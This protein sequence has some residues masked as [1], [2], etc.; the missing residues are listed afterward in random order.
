MADFI[1]NVEELNHYFCTI[2]VIYGFPY[3]FSKYF[4]LL[5]KHFQI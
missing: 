1:K 3:M 4:Y 5:Y 2:V